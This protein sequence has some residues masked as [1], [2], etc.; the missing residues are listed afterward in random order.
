[1]LAPMK[2]HTMDGGAIDVEP[3]VLEGLK[4]AVRGA[5]FL[6]GSHA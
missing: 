5:L 2:F 3:A 4:T 6:E 1:M